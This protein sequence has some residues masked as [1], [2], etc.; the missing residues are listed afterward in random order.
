[1][2]IGDGTGDRDYNKAMRSLRDNSAVLA[3]GLAL[4]LTLA[5]CGPRLRP[6][7]STDQVIL[8]DG[9][10]V[11]QEAEGVEIVVAP[12]LVPWASRTGPVG[13]LV[14]ISN[15]G[16]A[17]IEFKVNDLLLE[18]GLGRKFSPVQ[19]ETLLR[20]LAGATQSESQIRLISGRHRR[21]YRVRRRRHY[22]RPYSYGAYYG[23]GYGYGYGF[24]FGYG[25]G[26]G[27]GYYDSTYAQ[28]QEIARFLSG[29]LESQT[30]PPEHVVVGYI[31]FPYHMVKDDDVTVWYH[32]PTDHTASQPAD[33]SSHAASFRFSVD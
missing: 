6:L 5:G 2:I 8:H 28:Q 30:V 33:R 23:T 20:T 29:L 11:L 19:P 21:Y 10:A 25:Y 31:V 26:A 12:V 16:Q 18:D 24:G 7:E 14:E 13:F 32:L 3:T 4:G 27:D 9:R 22:A 1:M 17:A 15:V